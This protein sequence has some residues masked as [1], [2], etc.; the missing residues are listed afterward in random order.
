MRV[1]NIDLWDALATAIIRQVIR[2]NQARLMYQ[3]FC[4]AHGEAVPTPWGTRHLIPTAEV[5]AKLP[6]LAFATLGM[7]FKARALVAAAE[8]AMACQDSWQHLT[9][10]ELVTQLQRIPRVGPWTAG[11]TVADYSGDFSLY[12]Y[13]D[14][15]VRTWAR[16][17]APAID[18][19][20]DEPMFGAYWRRHTGRHLSD[21]TLLVLAWGGSRAPDS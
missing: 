4:R 12:P 17:A 10:I 5:V 21:L 9:P 16:R 6:T 20:G 18:W 15:A 19:P 8:A 11:A 2:A 3:R 1:R 7:A 13:A 14:L